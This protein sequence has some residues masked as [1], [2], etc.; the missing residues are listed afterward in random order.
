MNYHIVLFCIQLMQSG[1]Y[2]YN[3]VTVCTQHTETQS[4]IVIFQLDV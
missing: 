3:R 4:K 1:H 2:K